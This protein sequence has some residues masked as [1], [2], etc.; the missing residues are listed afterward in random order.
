MKNHCWQKQEVLKGMATLTG[1][2]SGGWGFN[3]W[4]EYDQLS[5]ERKDVC[6]SPEGAVAAV[7][8]RRQ[9]FLKPRFHPRPPGLA[10][11]VGLFS[12]ILASIPATTSTA[13]GFPTPP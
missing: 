13:T 3:V 9:G 5:Q 1:T 11:W 12:R 8:K 2:L 10:T 4:E 6:Y 7:A